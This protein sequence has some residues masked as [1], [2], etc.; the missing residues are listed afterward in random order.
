MGIGYVKEVNLRL[1]IAI[2][3]PED[4][5]EELIK[6][7]GVLKPYISNVK[8]VEKENLH[9]TLRFLGEIT[10]ER[11]KDIE[12]AVGEIAN[13]YSPFY[14]SLSGIGTFP[15]VIWVGIDEGKETLTEI[16]YKSEGALIKKGFPPADKAFSP[17]IT[18]G[19]LKKSAGK[20]PKEDFKPLRFLAD[21]ITIMQST[22]FSNGPVYNPVR[23]FPF[24]K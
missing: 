23:I 5:K 4:I 11:L 12:E 18:L 21:S 14:I 15:Y 2:E 3:L 17:H 13:S 7:E 10:E 1:F 8:W 9:I 22:L 6:I 24:N 19:R 20:T 16:A